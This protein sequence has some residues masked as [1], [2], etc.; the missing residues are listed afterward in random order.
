MSNRLHE[1][2]DPLFQDG[3]ECLLEH[4]DLWD[5]RKVYVIE[6]LIGLKEDYLEG[7][8]K[9]ATCREMILK[10]TRTEIKSLR[11]QLKDL[12]L[13]ERDKVRNAFIKSGVLNLKKYGY[14]NVNAKNLMIDEIYGAFFAS[15]LDGWKLD[16][17]LCPAVF[18]KYADEMI[19]EIKKVLK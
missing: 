18:V 7:L 4:G 3:L 2:H 10:D 19:N 8:G 6:T 5:A 1:I 13:S 14:P 16:E 12:K 15:M 17:S 9:D 11:K